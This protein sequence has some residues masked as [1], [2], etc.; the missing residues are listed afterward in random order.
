MCATV[1]PH[2]YLTHVENHTEESPTSQGQRSAMN[3]TSWTTIQNYYSPTKSIHM[4]LY[5]LRDFSLESRESGVTMLP[6][7]T[8][9][10]KRNLLAVKVSEKAK[11][12][13]KCYCPVFTLNTH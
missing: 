13:P 2:V 8:W 9:V 4:R 3:Q 7:A 1:G 12:T 11:S 6:H 5:L 10:S